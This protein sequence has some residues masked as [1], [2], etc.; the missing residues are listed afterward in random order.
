MEMGYTVEWCGGVRVGRRKRGPYI[1]GLAEASLCNTNQ[2]IYV[3]FNMTI[4]LI[5]KSCWNNKRPTG[6]HN[7]D[8]SNKKIQ[9]PDILLKK[10]I[11]LHK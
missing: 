3:C 1:F 9:R 10:S 2:F 8:V 11:G 5:Y 6:L 7:N 4:F